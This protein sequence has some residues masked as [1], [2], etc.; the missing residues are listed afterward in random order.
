MERQRRAAR[1]L[2]LWYSMQSSIFFYCCCS[3]IFIGVATQQRRI[4]AGSTFEELHVMTEAVMTEAEHRN[5]E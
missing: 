5:K 3:T 2:E 4:D 1:A